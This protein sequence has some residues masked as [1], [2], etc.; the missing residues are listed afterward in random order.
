MP[1]CSCARWRQCSDQP[2][3]RR[4]RRCRRRLAATAAADPS[5]P[6]AALYIIPALPNVKD[7]GVFQ[8]VRAM[9]IDTVKRLAPA[10]TLRRHVG[11]GGVPS[12]CDN[13]QPPPCLV[14]ISS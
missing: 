7:A 9:Y 14:T 5:C 3:R 10:G 12:F 6:R 2:C 13:A 11:F 8:L 4:R 1:V